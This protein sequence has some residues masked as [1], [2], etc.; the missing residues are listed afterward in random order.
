METGVQ[1]RQAFQDWTRG[2]TDLGARIS[3]FEHVRDIPYAIVPEL[4]HAENYVKILRE[5]RGSC[6]P[7]HLLLARMFQWLGLEVFLTVC[8]FRWADVP[9]DF[10]P[11]LRSIIAC[12]PDDHHMAC[13]VA[14]EGGLILVDA[15]LDTS[16][17]PLGLPVNTRWD[18]ISHTKLA[19][20]PCGPEE[21]FHPSEVSHINQVMIDESHLEFFRRLNDWLEEVRKTSGF[22]P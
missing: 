12:L 2:K 9:V 5:G 17:E 13:R 6:T 7:K 8:P 20:E 16:L 21:L 4:S 1:V 19:V 22:N 18:G 14:L 15:T 11:D 3:V 10:P